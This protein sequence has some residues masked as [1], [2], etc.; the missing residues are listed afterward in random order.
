MRLAYPCK[1]GRQ[2]ALLTLVPLLLLGGCGS[3]DKKKP[4]QPTPEAGYVVVKTQRVPLFVELAGRTSAYET[5]EVRPQV[6]GII[7]KRLF[8]EGAIVHQGQTLYQIDPSLYRASAAQARANVQSAEALRVS[9]QARADRYRP[10]AAIEAVAKQDL[11][12]A[13]ATAKQSAAA[14]AQNR[15]ALQTAQINLRF[16]RVP[17][18]I[19][20]RIGRSLFTTGALVTASQTSPLTTIQRLDP[21]FVDIQQSSADLLTLRR[22][23]SQGGVVPSTAAV[24]LTLEDGSDYGITGRVQFAEVTVDQS[25]GSV[26][27][28]A[29]FPNPNG[30]LLPGMYVRARMSQA[31]AQNAILVPQAAVTRDPRGNASVLVVGPNNKAVQRMV[32][33]DRTIGASWLVSSGLKPGEKVISEGLVRVKAG[34]TIKPVP[35]GSKPAPVPQAKKG[36]SGA[37]GTR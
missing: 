35:A 16:T 3:K 27:L 31:T 18:P 28:R 29:T 20:G 25:T 5:S 17:A 26:T 9:S 32:K 33:A 37:S 36:D 2:A 1:I 10:L 30:L 34:Q 15:A 12:D 6:N 11:T 7:Q 23:L 8:T 22:A 14:V 19:T 24:T 21:I 13:E 4:P